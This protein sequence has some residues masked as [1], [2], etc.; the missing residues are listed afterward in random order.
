MKGSNLG[1]NS[2]LITGSPSKLWCPR[3]ATASAWASRASAVR[4]SEHRAHSPATTRTQSL[5]PSLW[6]VG[7]ETERLEVF[8]SDAEI[9]VN[10]PFVGSYQRSL[11]CRP[12]V[13]A[14]VSTVIPRRVGK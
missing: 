2:A 14:L 13:I 7:Y 6:A 12:P 8:G 10:V 4:T 11:T 3:P 5:K 9:T 1:S